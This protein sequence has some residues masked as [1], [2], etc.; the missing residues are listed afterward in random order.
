MRLGAIIENL[1]KSY[2]MKQQ[3]DYTPFKTGFT[4]LD[5]LLGG[6][7]EPAAVH[8]LTAKPGA[9]K[10]SFIIN[11]ALHNIAISRPCLL[12]SCEM[13][14]EDFVAKFIATYIN[15]NNI[16]IKELR[17]GQQSNIMN[18]ALEQL[19]DDPIYIIGQ[20]SIRTN[21]FSV[22]K[23]EIDDIIEKTGAVPFVAI[24]Y[25]QRFAGLISG[26]VTQDYRVMIDKVSSDILSI[27][28][29][30]G[31]CI[32][33]I[34]STGR[35]NYR[36]DKNGVLAMGKESGQLEFDATTVSGLLP[37]TYSVEEDSGIQFRFIDFI[38]AKSRFGVTDWEVTFKFY[39]QTGKFEEYDWSHI[40]DIKTR[41]VNKL[42]KTISD[43]NFK[44]QKEIAD[45]MGWDTS[46]VCRMM[47]E[48][49][50]TKNSTGFIC[51]PGD[52]K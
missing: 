11:V 23:K 36:N 47:K 43:N 21:G 46:K 5:R 51:L 39:G 40:T 32:L 29:N 1:R 20:N 16:S 28:N 45:H 25:I 37:N 14:V 50:T 9:G 33:A 6:G 35:Q 41:N 44:T 12:I 42:I 31:A 24:D 3:R 17:C 27:A 26:N 18:Q 10:T 15:D 30:S 8:L 48:I 52:E 22:I 38:N 4:E 2:D 7:F 34:S 49:N 13:T 19:K